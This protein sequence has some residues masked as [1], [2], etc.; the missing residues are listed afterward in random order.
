MSPVTWA[1]YIGALD[2]WRRAAAALAL[3]GLSAAALPP[4]YATPALVIAFPGLVWL[5]DG[6]VDWKRAF[7]DGWWFGFG[8]F[9]GG[10]YWVAKA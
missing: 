5:I 10:L 4:V 1:H 9:I 7:R 6:A 8:H 2:G 3:G